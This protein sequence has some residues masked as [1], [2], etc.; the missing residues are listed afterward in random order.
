[1]RGHR[2][3]A[4]RAHNANAWLAWHVEALARQKKLPSLERLML[5]SAEHV[6]E[7]RQTPEQMLAIAR[8]LTLAMGGRIVNRT[9]H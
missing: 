4:V 8:M 9:E 7:K 3:A 5:R 6:V 1:M 2:E